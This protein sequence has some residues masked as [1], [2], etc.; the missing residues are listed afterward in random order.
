MNRTLVSYEAISNS[1]TQ[2][3]GKLEREKRLGE[4]FF[5]RYAKNFPKFD[6]R[7][8]FCMCKILNTKQNEDKYAYVESLYSQTVGSER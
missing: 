6:E 3:T 4:K 1:P 8:K 2:E 7:Q 5:L